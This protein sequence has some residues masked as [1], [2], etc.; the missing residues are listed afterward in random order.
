MI[1]HSSQR[2]YITYMGFYPPQ[3]EIEYKTAI[4]QS[5]PKKNHLVPSSP[6][7][8]CLS[9]LQRP[10][11]PKVTDTSSVTAQKMPSIGIKRIV[12]KLCAITAKLSDLDHR[13]TT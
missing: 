4:A 12:A 11:T 6:K 8:L 3:R 10:V 9:R 1:S 7:S 2:E 13:S 5:N